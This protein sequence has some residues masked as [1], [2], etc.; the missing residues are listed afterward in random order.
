MFFDYSADMSGQVTKELKIKDLVNVQNLR[1]KHPVCFDCLLEVLQ[2]LKERVAENEADRDMFKTQ[3]EAIEEE[4]KDQAD[5]GLQ[6][7]L[8]RL[9]AE[10]QEL[11]RKL[12]QM[13]NEE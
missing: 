11:D 5:E 7:E 8:A 3:L 9:E 10:E 2:Q 12:S 4:L 13:E 1:L 6:E